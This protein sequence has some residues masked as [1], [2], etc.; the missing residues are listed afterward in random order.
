MYTW[1]NSV[2]GSDSP[3]PEANILSLTVFTNGSYTPNNLVVQTG[4]PNVIDVTLKTPSGQVVNGYVKAEED[5]G[6][7]VMN[8]TYNSTSLGY[9]D[10]I[11]DL[12]W[13]PTQQQFVITPTSYG[14]INS[15]VNLEVYDSSYAYI[16]TVKLNINPNLEPRLGSPYNNDDLKVIINSMAAVL[17]SLYYA[18][19]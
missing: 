5:K 14:P 6:Y 12:L 3:S 19:N 7:L 17:N 15:T 9:K 16:T 10:H 11:Y 2:S 8:P 4:A 18:L 1:A 13:M